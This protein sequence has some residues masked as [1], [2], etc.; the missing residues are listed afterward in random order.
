[1]VTAKTALPL[2]SSN[3]KIKLVFKEGFQHRPEVFAKFFIK[4]LI[5]QSIYRVSQKIVR[6]LIKY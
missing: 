2:F 4:E 5:V 1:M 6:R 3:V